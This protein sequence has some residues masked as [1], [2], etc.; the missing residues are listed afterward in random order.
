M[1]S[2]QKQYQFEPVQPKA[3]EKPPAYKCRV[4][5]LTATQKGQLR[6]TGKY[7]EVKVIA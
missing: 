4:F 5:G 1:N 7:S 6:D 2:L 3:A